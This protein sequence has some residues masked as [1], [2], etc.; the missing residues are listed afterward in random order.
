MSQDNAFTPASTVDVADDLFSCAGDSVTLHAARCADCGAV[1]FP[2]QTS[3]PRCT[4]A[5]MEPQPL[6]DRGTLWSYTIQRFCPKSPYDGPGAADFVPYGVGYVL[7]DDLVIVEGRLTE[8][9]PDRLEIGQL[10]KVVTE[11]YTV[12]SDG[13]PVVTFAFQPLV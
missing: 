8:N 9:E 11:H 12:N 6:P 13:V 1:V 4:G 10:V 2:V 7:F 3:C 5:Q